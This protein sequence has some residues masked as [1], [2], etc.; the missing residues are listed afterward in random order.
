MNALTEY[1]SVIRLDLSFYDAYNWK[2][3]NAEHS[4]SDGRP[5]R[6]ALCTLL[7]LAV[8]EP[9]LTKFWDNVGDP[10]KLKIFVSF[11]PRCM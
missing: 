4:Q 8:C 3:S 7:V 10:S 6:H 9:K 5:V 2:Q 11:L 1:I